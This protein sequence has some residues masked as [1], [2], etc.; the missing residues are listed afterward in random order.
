MVIKQDKCV[1]ENLFSNTLN[2][3]YEKLEE[4]ED[5]PSP[6]IDMLRENEDNDELYN[7]NNNYNKS[8]RHKGYIEN[9]KLKQSKYFGDK[10]I[11][12]KYSYIYLI[13]QIFGSGIVSIP[14]IFKHSGWLPCLV[15]NIII[16]LLTIFNTLLFLRSMTMIPNNIHFNKRYEYISTMC[17]FLG[18]NNIFFMFMQICYY[19]SILVSNIISIVIVSHAVDY[20]LVNIFGY[21]IGVII[22]PNFQFSTI[23]DINKLYY[24]NNY[25][26]CITIGYVINAIISIYFS[27]SSL[28][29]NMKVQ[30]LSFIFLMITIFQI[31]FL[32]IIKIYK[33]NNVHTILSNDS[34]GKYSDIKYPTIFGDFNFKQLLSSYISSYSAITV[35][36]CWANEMKSDVKIMKTVWISNF[37]CCFIYYI[38]GY[39]LYT[40]YPH[41]DNENILYGIL[42]NPSINTSMKVSIYLFDLLTIAPGIYVYCIATRYNLV[43]SN[44]CSEKAAFLFGTVFPFLISWWFTSRAMFESIFT[45]SSLIFSYAC[46]Y[47][48]PS[49]I[50]LI[51][52]KNIPYSQK[53]PLHYI[54]VLYDPNEY[55]QKNFPLY[56]VFS[57]KNNSKEREDTSSNTN[58]RVLN[59]R[60]YNKTDD[61]DAFKIETGDCISTK[62]SY[63]KT[64]QH[65][66]FEKNEIKFDAEEIYKLKE[67]KTKE[68]ENKTIINDDSN[69]VNNNK[70][71]EYKI[72]FKGLNQINN[73][74]EDD[75]HNYYDET[76]ST[77]EKKITYLE[78]GEKESQQQSNE[79]NNKAIG[80]SDN[81]RFL[82]NNVEN[83]HDDFQ[84]GYTELK[85]ICEENGNEDKKFKSPERIKN[86]YKDNNN[87]NN[88]HRKKS[89]KDLK[90]KNKVNISHEYCKKNENKLSK[91]ELRKYNSLFNIKGNNI[92]KNNSKKTNQHQVHNVRKSRKH[93][94]VIGFE[95]KHIKIPNKNNNINNNYY[96]YSNISENDI[97]ILLI[98]ISI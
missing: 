12:K 69:N 27:Q 26:L 2:T 41:I 6:N 15:I 3:E 8:D 86:S 39:V 30:V 50:Y 10:T 43:N 62:N 97:E 38:F 36:P 66:R 82:E 83:T 14:Y 85:D 51:A 65:P 67:D 21:T 32:S 25:V 70:R 58:P 28:E 40:A 72:H 81:Y 29:D 17:Y 22:Y 60:N 16:C 5:N 57:V 76:K 63:N 1:T 96:D 64:Y 37:F 9:I 92:N 53:N 24:S 84:N 7:N 75:R 11:G 45:W 89:D 20:I 68:I 80:L 93:K 42:K 87:N 79:D 88:Y 47:I 90:K 35:I 74:E 23:T 19:G 44:I 78:G 34:M 71:G 55:K 54:H 33:Y 48:T 98:V 61:P 52:C 56:N 59:E 31:I 77:E 95:K 46:N 18:K 91:F 13:N 4:I 49:I 94:T 73:L